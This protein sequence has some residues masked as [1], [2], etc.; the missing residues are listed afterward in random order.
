PPGGGARAPP[1]RAAPRLRRAG[2]RRPVPRRLCP[3]DRGG[4]AGVRRGGGVTPGGVT[5]GDEAL[6][7]LRVQ[8][9]PFEDA[10]A[11]LVRAVVSSPAF[12]SD[13][14]EAAVRYGLNL[15][16]TL[17]IRTPDGGDLDL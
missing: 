4:A 1:A 5:L 12:L 10:E 17:R 6:D 11:A 9:R 15:A 3:G 16:R 14:D 7:A 13:A 2:S 8:V